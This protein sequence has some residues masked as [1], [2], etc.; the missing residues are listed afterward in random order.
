MA[1]T[2]HN[3]EIRKPIQLSIGTKKLK[4]IN[5]TNYI[6]KIKNQKAQIFK[7]M[8]LILLP[9]SVMSNLQNVHAG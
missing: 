8:K 4:F 1:S 2:K 6:Q 3:T 9:G 7:K 5:L